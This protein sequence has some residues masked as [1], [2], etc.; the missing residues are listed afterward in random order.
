MRKYVAIIIMICLS[1]SLL[2]GCDGS[3]GGDTNKGA[4]SK[5]EAQA[6][7]VQAEAQQQADA[8]QEEAQQQTD[9]P[10]TEMKTAEAQADE[11]PEKKLT[12]QSLSKTDGYLIFV[13][14]ANTEEPLAGVK[15][16]FCSD[17]QC[18]MGRTD[19][20]GVA[21]F[22]MEPGNY[23]AHILKQPEGYQKNKETAKLTATDKTAVFLL[24]KEGEEL[25]TADA[26]DG[27]EAA[28]DKADTESTKDMFNDGYQKTDAEWS[29]DVTGFTFKVPERFKDYKGQYHGADLGESDFNSDIFVTNLIYLPRTDEE[30]AVM[31]DYVK[32]ITDQEANSDE[33]RNRVDEYFR[34]NMAAA[35]IVAIKDGMDFDPVLDEVSGDRSR[36]RKTGEL[37]SAGGYTYYYVIPDYSVYDD[38][39]KE[40]LPEDLFAEYQD[41]MANVEQDVLNGVTLKGAHRVFEVTPIGTQLSFETTDLNGN[42]VSTADL[43]AGHKVTMVNL[44]AT[45]CTYCKNEMPELE[46]LSKELAEKDCQIIGIC[47]DVEDDNVQEAIRILEER[48]V[49]YTNIKATDEMKKT[50]FSIG[51]PTTYFVDSEGKVLTNPVKGVDFDKYSVRLEEALKAVE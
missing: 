17:T 9:A 2:M 27:S 37:G 19:N 28:A 32:G 38:M 25:K 49:T 35:M 33:F 42:A 10:K 50:L 31:S 30:R 26:A 39:L 41:V 45:W 4:Q 14:D 22:N 34:F 8:V 20:T 11:Q 43:F 48:G 13:K 5:T 46:E 12:S 29:F 6:E 3:G 47:W 1:A 16:Q 15:V 23:E 7:T 36:V 51:L 18:M 44:W 21:V 40:A 24:L